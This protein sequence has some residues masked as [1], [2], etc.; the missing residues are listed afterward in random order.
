VPVTIT[1]DQTA[2]VLKRVRDLTAKRVLVGIT[3]AENMRDDGSPIGNAAIG[4]I[5]EHGDPEHNLPARPFL[6]PGVMAVQDKSIA[7]L[8]KAGE[9]AL[10]GGD[11]VSQMTA[12]GL[13]AETSVK[14][15]ITD[16]I[17]PPLAPRT[18][19]ERKAAGFQGE[20]PLIRTGALR[21]SITHVIEDKRNG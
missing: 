12:A 16:I 7:R 1:K 20:T 4:Y 15:L 13:E 19:A 8:R 3:A 21:N 18:L 6:V 2:V 17:P 5:Q 14:L 10:L 9:A 11:P